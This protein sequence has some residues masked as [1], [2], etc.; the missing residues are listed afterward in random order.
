M[1]LKHLFLL[2]QIILEMLV[3]FY[4][5]T[6]LYLLEEDN[7]HKNYLP[8]FVSNTFFIKEAPLKVPLFLKSEKTSKIALSEFKVL[9]EVPSPS[10]EKLLNTKED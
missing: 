5:K 6:N 9:K 3:K 4:L 1:E 7:Q 10:K 2:L 8:F